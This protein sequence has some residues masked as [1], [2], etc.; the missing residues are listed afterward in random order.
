MGN[1]QPLGVVGRVSEPKLLVG[2]NLRIK[3]LAIIIDFKCAINDKYS[4][5]KMLIFFSQ[6]CGVQ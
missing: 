3:Y 5:T 4:G 1:F 2:E 6:S